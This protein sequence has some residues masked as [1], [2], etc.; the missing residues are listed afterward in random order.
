MWREFFKACA[1]VLVLGCASEAPA[2]TR[3]VESTQIGNW[4]LTAFAGDPDEFASCSIKTEDQ[5]GIEF[6]VWTDTFGGWLMFLGAKQ[7]KLEEGADYDVQ[8]T[9]DDGAP[10]AAQ[11]KA[12]IDNSVR[13]SLGRDF[14]STDLLRRGNRIAIKTAKETF[15]FDLAGSARAL[16][17]MRDCARRWLRLRDASSDP[18]SNAGSKNAESQ[19]PPD[20]ELPQRMPGSLSDSF[21][22]A[23]VGP[24]TI[25]AR[26]SFMN[27][28]FTYCS[29]SPPD[30]G[31]H[32]LFIELDRRRDWHM[33]ILN[34]GWRMDLNTRLDVRYSID[35]GPVVL[36]AGQPTIA[37]I[38]GVELGRE[39][40]LF[41]KLKSG[42]RLRF[43]ANGE[44]FS[45]DLSGAGRALNALSRCV[46]RYSAEG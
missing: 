10:I 25:N 20:P 30:A 36:V 11:A 23:D 3:K 14:A 41:D 1:L 43:Q 24:W 34:S 38:I 42:R 19:S 35:D 8:Y 45:F 26:T 27:G 18:F 44:E 22:P 17:A 4:N 37:Q 46:E 39:P 12:V 21:S 15:S 32:Q 28:A 31:P 29:V 5:A 6:G 33:A 2:E 16:D 40:A 13:V 9:I 7:W